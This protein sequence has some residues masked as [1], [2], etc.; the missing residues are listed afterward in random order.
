[1]DSL[2]PE[3][4]RWLMSRVMGKNTQPELVVRRLLHGL[5]YRFRLHPKDLPGRPDI[6]FKA[7]NKVIFVHGCFWHGHEGCR[8][9][10]LPN[11][12][13]KFW[14][15]KIEMNRA[16]DARKEAELKA[17]GYDVLTLWEC[18]LKNLQGVSVG[19][20]AF[21]GPTRR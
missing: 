20:S 12:R 6:T 13:I 2:T 7:R 5:G 8:K 3:R 11:T 21:L 10:K 1:M 16:R 4:R 18:D 14:R 15:D 17:L 9:A 19:L